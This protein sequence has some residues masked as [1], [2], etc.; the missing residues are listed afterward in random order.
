MALITFEDSAGTV[1]R[2]WNVSRETLSNGRND[3]LGAEFR[4]GWLCFQPEGGEERRRL[5][6][7]PEDWASLG[8][9]RLE[10]LCLAATPV[11]TRRVPAY[12]PAQRPQGP[13]LTGEMRRFEDR[14]RSR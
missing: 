3:Y 9:E 4:T 7:Y 5:A 14:D 11:I 13:S 1:W 12:D 2:V 8:P 10:A 6:N